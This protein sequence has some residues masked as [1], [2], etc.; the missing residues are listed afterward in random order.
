[1]SSTWFTKWTDLQEQS[2]WWI[3]NRLSLYSCPVWAPIQPGFPRGATDKSPRCSL[4]A[5]WEHCPALS[6]TCRLAKPVSRL[7]AF[8]VHKYKKPDCL[9]CLYFLVPTMPSQDGLVLDQCFFSKL[10][11]G[12][13]IP[14]TL[15]HSAGDCGVFLSL[16]MNFPPDSVLPHPFPEDYVSHLQRRTKRD[17][18]KISRSFVKKECQLRTTFF[19]I[20]TA[21]CHS[22]KAGRGSERWI[23]HI[24]H[25]RSLVYGSLSK[26][27]ART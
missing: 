9:D 2:K 21:L 7:T 27:E 3:W 6:R 26:Y 1:M 20:S 13:L 5:H 22:A 23:S 15:Y 18:K 19:N 24:I 11:H 8:K 12:L 10:G 14:K 25:A 4:N 17:T 16:Y